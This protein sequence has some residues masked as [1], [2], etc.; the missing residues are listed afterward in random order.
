[1][2]TPHNIR[3]ALNACEIWLHE[4]KDKPV[5]RSPEDAY[6]VLRAVLHAIR[7]RLPV[8][9]AAHLSAQLPMIVRG[10]YF[11][12]WDPSRAPQPLTEEQFYGRIRQTLQGH[13]AG[14]DARILA[15]CVFD[16]LNHHLT[17]EA[18]AHARQHLPKALRKE[19]PDVIEDEKDVCEDDSQ[20]L[21]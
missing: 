8:A 19:W 14:T 16:I 4:L 10:F 20:K 11:E 18:V 15:R 7:D 17:P 9:D 3:Q 2:M 12:G 13:C 21:H 1:M 5:I 6:A